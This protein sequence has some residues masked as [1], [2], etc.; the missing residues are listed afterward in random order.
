MLVRHALALAALA[1]LLGCAAPYTIR[2]Q[3]RPNPFAST[4]HASFAVLPLDFSS[5]HVESGVPETAWDRRQHADFERAKSAVSAAFQQELVKTLHD[6]GISVTPAVSAPAA[7]ADFII[8]PRVL[9]LTPGDFSG[10]GHPVSHIR[11]GAVITSRS[12][13][14]LDV[15][16]VEHG[17]VGD[18]LAGPTHRRMTLDGGHAGERLAI[19]LHNR[20]APGS[21][22]F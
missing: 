13:Q 14:V 16:E 4:R 21:E 12:G 20:V 7:S 18:Q 6:D 10:M 2:Q 9:E 22:T 15:V 11:V 19:Y 17:T 8:Q 3:S 1:S 5:A